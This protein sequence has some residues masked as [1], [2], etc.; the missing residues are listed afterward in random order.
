MLKSKPYRASGQDLREFPTYTI[1][2]AAAFLGI[3]PRTLRFWLSGSAPNLQAS[4][5]VGN[6]PLLS[7]N[8]AAE[9][10]ALFLLR[11]HYGLSM[12]SL[13]RALSNLPK[14]TKSKRPLIA[15]NLRVLA[16]SLI[17]DVLPRDK[18]NHHVVDLTHGSQL[19]IPHVADIFASR[20]LRDS[21]KRIEVLF[22]WRDWS[23]DTKS[24]PVQIDPSVM[25][26]RPVISGTRIP[27]AMIQDRARRGQSA[28]YIANDYGL[29]VES[30]TKALQ[31]F[32][33]KAA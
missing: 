17:L 1:P 4:G 18:S 27:V 13:R 22:P 12:Q 14:Y 24:R 2:E 6:L 31:H 10:Y 19:V 11:S 3:R 9:A 30:V 26:G 29:T 25:S 16:D 5:S 28:E 8:D 33:T 21:A 20:V 32:D 15:D 7:F 23:T